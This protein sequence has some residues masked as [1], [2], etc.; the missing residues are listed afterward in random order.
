M[1]SLHR[2]IHSVFHNRVPGQLVIQYTDQCNATCPQCGMRVTER[3][4][5]VDDRNG[6]NQADHRRRG[7]ARG[8]ALSFTGGEPLLFPD[9]L[10]EMIRYA[11][12]AGIEM[13]RTGTNG[14]LF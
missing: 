10:A 7:G 12:S 6:R 3:F 14:Y 11:G 4:P 2:F 5:P 9:R 13:I 8:S 1:R